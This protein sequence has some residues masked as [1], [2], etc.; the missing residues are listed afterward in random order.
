MAV[1][2]AVTT[3][4][5]TAVAEYQAQP[6]DAPLRVLNSEPATIWHKLDHLLY[7]PLLGL[8]RPADLSYYH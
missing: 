8:T 7:L 1:P 6:A 3:T 5:A 4:L 2:Q